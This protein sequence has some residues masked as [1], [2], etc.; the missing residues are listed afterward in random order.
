MGGAP[1]LAVAREGGANVD[2]V[3]APGVA[4]RDAVVVFRETHVDAVTA[5]RGIGAGVAG[6]PTFRATRASARPG[7][8]AL[9][10]ARRAADASSAA[11]PGFTALP[12]VTP[13]AGVASDT[14]C[15]AAAVTA[16]SGVAR[17]SEL[18]TRAVSRIAA[19]ASDA[20]T[21]V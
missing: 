4:E 13:G 14:S 10:A 17:L 19:G 6:L 7:L 1:L 18:A 11:R 5:C 2:D 12:G 3:K 21:R 8:T 15:T 9:P 20:V 16:L